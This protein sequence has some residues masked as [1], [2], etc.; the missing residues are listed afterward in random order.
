MLTLIVI[1]GIIGFICS[2][3]GAAAILG[4]MYVVGA[5]LPFILLG[6]LFLKALA[7]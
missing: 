1:L 2:A 4:L 6:F 7:H 5:G 3:E